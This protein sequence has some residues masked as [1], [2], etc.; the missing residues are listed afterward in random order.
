MKESRNTFKTKRNTVGH[1]AKQRSEFNMDTNKAQM[2]QTFS[3]FAAQIQNQGNGSSVSYR[4]SPRQGKGDLGPNFSQKTG[5]FLPSIEK[6][7]L[8]MAKKTELK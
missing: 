6:T 4:K 7:E 1:G 2:T 8:K 3:S 5:Q